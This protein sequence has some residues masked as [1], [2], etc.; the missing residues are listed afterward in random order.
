MGAYIR[1]AYIRRFTFCKWYDLWHKQGVHS[2]VIHIFCLLTLHVSTRAQSFFR[3]M[4][5]RLDLDLNFAFVCV[6]TLRHISSLFKIRT[7][8]QVFTSSWKYSS[9][10][11]RFQWPVSRK[12]CSF[13]SLSALLTAQTIPVIEWNLRTID[14]E[15]ICTWMLLTMISFPIDTSISHGEAQKYT[16]NQ[17]ILRD[18]TSLAIVTPSYIFILSLTN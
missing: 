18:S 6:S 11:W 17:P 13:M 7:I 15:T 12:Q 16:I 5:S 3:A 1:G 14:K 9:R 8:H 4:Y 2:I 10:P